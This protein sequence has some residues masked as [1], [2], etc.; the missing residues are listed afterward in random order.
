MINVDARKE[1]SRH[2]KREKNNG[3]RRQFQTLHTFFLLNECNDKDFYLRIFGHKITET[4]KGA[5]NAP[6]VLPSTA[7]F[8]CFNRPKKQ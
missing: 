4:K 8:S 3:L 7:M 5:K 1:G 6:I 2:E